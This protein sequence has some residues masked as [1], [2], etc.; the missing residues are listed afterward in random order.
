M[1]LLQ[2]VWLLL[3]MPIITNETTPVEYLGVYNTEAKCHDVL[4]KTNPGIA[5]DLTCKK[6]I[7]EHD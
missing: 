1:I 5:K 2:A 3:S 4:S 7:P 6:Y